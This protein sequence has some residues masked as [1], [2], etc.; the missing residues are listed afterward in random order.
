MKV[1][2]ALETSTR[3][4]SLAG[5]AGER[6]VEIRLSSERAQAS[7]L[8]PALERLLGE[9]GATPLEVAGVLVGLGPGSYTGLRIGVATALGLARGCGA[10]LRGIPSSEALAFG[11]LEPGEECCQILDARQG[12]LYLAHYRRLEAELETLRAPCVLEPAEL[13]RALPPGIPL[14]CGPGAV[15]A[16]RLPAQVL[17]RVRLGA[18]PRARALLE[19]GLARLERLGPQ[20]PEEV[21]PLYLRAFA[22]RERERG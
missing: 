12:A 5:A 22:I 1:H 7:D 4:P 21:E 20:R 19:L 9:L 17:G 18:E 3:A 14:L 15:E 6:R 11:E 8:V 10:A 16:A 13:A 2:L